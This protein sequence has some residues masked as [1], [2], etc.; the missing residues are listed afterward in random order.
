V[1]GE[2]DGIRLRD[3]LARVPFLA[4]LDAGTLDDLASRMSIRR[5]A[6]E[7][8]VVTQEDSGDALFIV[9]S[10]RVKVVRF[11]DSGREVILALLKPGDFFGEMSLLD[12]GPRSA[13]VVA[14]EDTTLAVL[15]RDAFLRHL[16]ARPLTAIRIMKEL[17]GRLR[18]ANE[19]IAGLALEDVGVRLARKLIGMARDSGETADDGLLIPERP[20]QQ[21]LAHMVGT[22]RETVSRTLSSLARKG[23]IRSRGRSLVITRRF[24]EEAG[25][26]A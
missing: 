13:D 16:E 3:H 26:A 14:L 10:G 6:R 23:L 5:A 15:G 8:W 1:R 24:I 21:D 17:S 19:T 11:G 7:T 12:G 22:C 18:R 20:T 4:D 25:I 9:L 2:A